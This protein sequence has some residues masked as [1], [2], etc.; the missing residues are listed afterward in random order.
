MSFDSPP[1]IMFKIIELIQQT[2]PCLFLVVWLIVFTLKDQILV[3]QLSEAPASNV[4][5]FG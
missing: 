4:R 5:A 3:I 2:K 1:L